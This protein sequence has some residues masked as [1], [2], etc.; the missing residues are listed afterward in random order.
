MGNCNYKMERVNPWSFG[1][2]TFTGD[3]PWDSIIAVFQ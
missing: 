2:A 1:L 3:R